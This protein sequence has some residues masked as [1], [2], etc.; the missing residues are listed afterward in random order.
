MIVAS[1]GIRAW[2]GVTAQT[3][4]STGFTKAT[5][6]SSGVALSPATAGGSA[7]SASSEG[8][9]S[10]KPDPTNDRILVFTPGIYLVSGELAVS[11]AGASDV[12]AALFAAAAQ[13]LE[14][15]TEFTVAASGKVNGSFQTILNLTRTQALTGTATA[16]LDL[17][18]QALAGSTSITIEFASLLAM[19]L[20]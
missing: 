3:F 11:A 16:A 12:Q 14:A 7:W 4:N 2:S 17:R 10:V 9:L 8:D 13:V 6:W 15:T 19:R 1:G 5:P 20:E 18:L